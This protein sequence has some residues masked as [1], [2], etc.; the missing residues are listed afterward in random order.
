MIDRPRLHPLVSLVLAV[1]IGLL[2][3]AGQAPMGVWPATLAGVALF[4]WLMAGRSGGASF[5][6][7]YVVGLAMN[8]LTVS[9]VSVLGVGVGVA[10]VGYLSVWWGLM[11]LAISKIVTLRAWPVRPSFLA[12]LDTDIWAFSRALLV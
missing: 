7:G 8:T 11:A 12:K 1:A 3:G 6:L 2:I 4:T 10:L 5:G 9:W